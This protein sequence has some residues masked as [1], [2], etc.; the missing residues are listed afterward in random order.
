[1]Y[2]GMGTQQ[3]S[4]PDKQ[5]KNSPVTSIKDTS[6]YGTDI[7]IAHFKARDLKLRMG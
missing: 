1:M 4:I 3:M 7:K 2:D 5:S 6:A